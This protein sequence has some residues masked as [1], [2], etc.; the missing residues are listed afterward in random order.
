[1]AGCAGQR[2]Q[3]A[4]IAADTAASGFAARTLADPGLGPFVEAALGHQASPWPPETWDLQT[5]SLAAWYFN[6]ALDEARAHIAGAN[7]ALMTAAARPNP[8]LSIAPGVPSP[9]LLTLDW[10]IPLETAGKRG[11][12]IQAARSLGQAARFDLANCAWKIRSGVRAGLL[13]Y[14]LAD[15]TL[16]LLRAEAQDRADQVRVLEQLSSAGEI[17]RVD[18]DAARI[19]LSKSR[20]AMSSG[21]GA[22]AEARA[23]LAAAVGI[24]VAG[25]QQ[26]RFTW[27]GLRTPPS[28]ESLSLE[29]IQR[30][31]V[32][33]RL[34]VRSSLAQYAAAEADLQLEIAKQYPDVNIGPGYVYEERRS[35]FT[36]GLSA[37][38]PLFDRNQGPIAEAEA[39]R[40]QAAATFLQTQSRVI[41]DS[42]RARAVYSAALQELAE[43][44]Y[45]VKLQ[46]GQRRAVQDSVR[47]GEQDRLD[48]LGVRIQSSLAA[49]ARLDALA[50]AQTALG[51]LEDAVQRPLAAGEELSLPPES[52]ALNKPPREP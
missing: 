19:E 36:V 40:Q 30:D 33:N 16:E 47:V 51:D 17:A 12:R 8:T 50:H 6:P 39:R 22:L 37:V 29:H 41:E 52:P 38:I 46:D 4:P 49:R 25:L 24:P 43:A 15:Q 3:P 42:E 26:V 31:A 23:A 7:A 13:N 11:Y 2:F 5:L 44:E 9:Y 14:L 20:L 21:A 32:L 27:Q 48:L 34:D 10:S 45:L 1:M 35:Y 28:V 18:A